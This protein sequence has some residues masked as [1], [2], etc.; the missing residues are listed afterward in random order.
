MDIAE[1][2]T[3]AAWEGDAGLAARLLGAGADLNATNREHRT[4]LDLAVHA[5]HAEVVRVLLAAGAPLDGP[6]GPYH[7]LNLMCLAAMCGRTEVVALLLDAGVRVDERNRDG[8]VPVVVAAGGGHRETVALLLDRG[9]DVDDRRMRNGTTPLGV[10]AWGGHAE[11][12]RLLLDRGA[13]PTARA[14]ASARSAFGHRPEDRER[15]ELVIALLTPGT[16]G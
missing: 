16:P 8:L 7:E 12:V 1:Q 11:V 9:A 5:G 2:L 4:A 14:L 15:Y 10:A 6:A 13:R 3:R